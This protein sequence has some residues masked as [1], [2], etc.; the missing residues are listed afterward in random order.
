LVTT[1]VSL[2]RRVLRSGKESA[3][4][5]TKTNMDIVERTRPGVEVAAFSA[6]LAARTSELLDEPGTLS[7]LAL[8][9][10]VCRLA[11]R[12]D[13]W[14]PLVIVDRERR[15]YEL[16]YEDD[17]VD[18]WVLSWMPGQQTGFHDH[19]RSDVGL[20]Q[21]ELNE[22]SLAIASEAEDGAD[23]AGDVSKRARRL[24]PRGLAPCR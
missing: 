23:V 12:P 2:A 10:L 14:Q 16:L 24:H 20:V 17:R 5:D 9:E 21:G 4:R 15:R 7:S 1:F 3:R 11:E 6:E 8:E 13:L 22:R 18:I 19:D